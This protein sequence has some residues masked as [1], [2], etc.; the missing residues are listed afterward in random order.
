M[1]C[2]YFGHYY[3]YENV[4]GNYI[5]CVC[6]YVLVYSC[7]ILNHTCSVVPMKCLYK[8]VHELRMHN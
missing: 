8:C 5:H 7:S 2:A 3:N 1:Q 6:M 4:Q